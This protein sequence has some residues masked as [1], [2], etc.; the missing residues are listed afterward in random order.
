MPARVSK[1]QWMADRL[2][3]ERARGQHS[4][5]INQL[6]VYNKDKM[7]FFGPQGKSAKLI[8]EP[9]AQTTK[10]KAS[11]LTRQ[12]GHNAPKG[13]TINSNVDSD[14][15]ASLSWKDGVA[16]AEFYRGGAVVYDYPMELE[17]FLDWVDSD[18]IGK[19]GNDFVF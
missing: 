2:A 17:E 3:G 15:L 16:T 19:Y 5:K 4:S 8:N 18:S 13:S 6:P 7:D 11:Q 1:E 14:C 12:I 9:I 10:A